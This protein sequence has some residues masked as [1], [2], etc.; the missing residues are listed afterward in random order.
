VSAQPHDDPRWVRT[1]QALLG[2][3][4]ELGD[5]EVQKASVGSLSRAAGVHRTS[6][7]NHFTSL[8]EAGAAALAIG[9]REI[10]RD[11]EEARRA[12]APPDQVAYTTIDRTLD[13]LREHRGLYL[14]ASD[15][16]SPTGLRGVADVV[17]QQLQDYRAHFG[18]DQVDRPREVIAAEDF[19]VASAIEG[20]Y[21]AVLHG[22]L[23]VDR[24]TAAR[25]LYDL[26]PAWMR[27]P[28]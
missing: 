26:L 3:L 9:M 23:D 27:S 18:A 22:G 5:E 13:Y 24:S 14:V 28:T 6:F 19:Y 16:R 4:L 15:W 7:Y 1:R 21:A 8:P 11:D 10:M 2:T 17:S 20:F 25:I 12:G